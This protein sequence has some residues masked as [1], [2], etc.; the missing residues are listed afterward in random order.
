[1]YVV[2]MITGFSA[3]VMVNSV[4]RFVCP[5]AVSYNVSNAGAHIV[6]LLP[7]VADGCFLTVSM[8]ILTV[9]FGKH[10]DK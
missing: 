8:V 9:I 2:E 1:M 6:A 10:K 4:A 3:G 7:T 5:W